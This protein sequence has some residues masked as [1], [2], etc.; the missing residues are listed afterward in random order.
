[1]ILN[2][3]ILTFIIY[4]LLFLNILYFVWLI[5]LSID[6]QKLKVLKNE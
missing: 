6:I 3:D 1:M 5:N 2:N 4:V